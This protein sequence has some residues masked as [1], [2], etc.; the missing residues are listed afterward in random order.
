MCP[1]LI[2]GP[3]L[4]ESRCDCTRCIRDRKPPMRKYFVPNPTF[5]WNPTED[6]NRLWTFITFQ[7]HGNLQT[8]SKYLGKLPRYFSLHVEITSRCIIW[9]I[10]AT[11]VIVVSTKCAKPSH[12][13]SVIVV[14]KSQ[15]SGSV[16]FELA[17]WFV[18]LSIGYCDLFDGECMEMHGVYRNFDCLFSQCCKWLEKIVWKKQYSTV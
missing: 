8:D 16:F 3:H 5:A 15:T 10:G 1:I 12:V 17:S 11:L 4:H 13:C 18:S 2:C 9:R 6:I 7:N 14:G